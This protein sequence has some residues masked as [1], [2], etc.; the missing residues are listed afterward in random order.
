MEPGDDARERDEEE[1]RRHEIG[2]EDPDSDPA[3]P[4][5]GQPRERV[6]GREGQEERDADDDQPGEGGVAEPAE[7]ERLAQEKPEVL[8]RR[9]FVEDERIILE[10]IEVPRALEARDE[11]PIEREGEQDG[12]DGENRPVKRAERQLP[13]ADARHQVTS[14]RCAERSISQ[15]TATSS[16]T[17]KI[18]I[19]APSARSPP[20]IPVKNAIEGRTWVVS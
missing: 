8:E 9:L 7:E 10:V 12:E 17:R 19:A 3:S 15:A 2:Q 1:R 11:H 4:A 13:R 5:A 18:E 16:G 20:R 6:R 14:V